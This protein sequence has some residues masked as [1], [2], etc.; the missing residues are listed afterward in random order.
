ME[1]KGDYAIFSSGLK[2]YTNNGII[3]LAPDLT[4]LEGYDGGMYNPEYDDEHSKFSK[5]DLVELA[6]Y[7]IAQ[8]TKFKQLQ[9]DK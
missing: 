3:G 8:W 2:V 1:I 5:A 9:E 7:M 4:V 6:D